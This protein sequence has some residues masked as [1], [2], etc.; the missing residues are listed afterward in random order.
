ML[1]IIRSLLHRY[2]TKY[3][4]QSCQNKKYYSHYFTQHSSLLPDKSYF[5]EFF[6]RVGARPEDKSVRFWWTILEYVVLVCVLIKIRTYFYTF[7]IF[8]IFTLLLLFLSIIII[9]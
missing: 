6:G 8:L 4:C 3:V 7:Y 2:R 9:T 1:K 5:D